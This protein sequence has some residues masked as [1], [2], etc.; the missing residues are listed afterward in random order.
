[1][2]LLVR[3]FLSISSAINML[4][5]IR[6]SCILLPEMSAYRKDCDETKYM[7]FLIKDGELLKNIIKF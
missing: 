2:S 1:M 3:K 6:P 4:K 7:F 5:K